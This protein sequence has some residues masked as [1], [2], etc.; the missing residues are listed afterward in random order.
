MAITEN[1]QICNLALAKIGHTAFI[2]AAL[3]TTPGTNLAAKIC[4]A[5]FEAERDLLMEMYP[6]RFTLKRLYYDIDNFQDTITATTAASPVV[7]TGTDIS[8]ANI[9]DDMGVYIWDTGIDDLDSEIFM[10]K[11]LNDTLQTFELYYTDGVTPYDGSSI[12][13]ASAGYFRLSPLTEYGYAYKLPT[14]CMRVYRVL[15]DYMRWE[16]EGDYIFADDSLLSMEYIA[17]V[18]TV[19]DF[20]QVF[21]DCLATKLAAELAGAIADKPALK[22]AQLRIFEEIAL[23]RAFRIGAIEAVPKNDQRRK[24]PSELSL[25]QKAGR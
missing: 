23:P 19:S 6:W 7:V 17:N 8:D 25:W 4:N 24:S 10:V 3:L 22:I 13:T 21:I 15:G 20:P 14:D 18:T 12:S 9:A 16:R 2:T 1:Y 5:I 11:N